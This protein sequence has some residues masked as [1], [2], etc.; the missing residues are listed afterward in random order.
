MDTNPD[1]E[2]NPL[3]NYTIPGR[4][5]IIACITGGMFGFIAYVLELLPGF[6]P[7]RYPLTFFLVPVVL[8][9]LVIYVAGCFGLRALGIR[10]R[11]DE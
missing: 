3:R 9:T 11:K 7:G 8:I 2:V 6:P 1:D 4:L 10:L 5:W